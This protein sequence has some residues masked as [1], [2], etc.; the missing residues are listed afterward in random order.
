[1]KFNIITIVWG[2]NGTHSIMKHFNFSYLH[3][4]HHVVELKGSVNLFSCQEGE[5]VLF[6]K[7]LL[8]KLCLEKVIWN[9]MYI[10]C[11]YFKELN[12]WL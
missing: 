6:T 7:Q 12:D 8:G 4:L 1:M 10:R 11:Y 5:I 3:D 2:I 9:H